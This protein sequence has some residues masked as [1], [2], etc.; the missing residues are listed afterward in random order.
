MQLSKLD[1]IVRYLA[2]ICEPVRFIEIEGWNGNIV[3]LNGIGD[4]VWG[5]CF[6]W[7][8]GVGHPLDSNV[9]ESSL[10]LKL[11][12]GG[13]SLILSILSELNCLEYCKFQ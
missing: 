10:G 9:I 4:T 5:C 1:G 12:V 11:R 6:N 8:D 2:G 3:T 13:L 7:T